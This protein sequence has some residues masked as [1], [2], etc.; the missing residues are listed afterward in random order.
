MN[1]N[2]LSCI[3]LFLFCFSA[4]L[5]SQTYQLVGNPVVTTGWDI[6][7]SASVS[8]DFIQLTANQTGQVGGIKLNAPI[9]LK[10][11]DKWRVEFDFRI[12]GIGTPAYGNGDGFAF[13]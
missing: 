6:V 10:Y 9:N 11:C 13:W 1:K 12:D 7:P 3:A 8:G 4:L 5:K 2:L